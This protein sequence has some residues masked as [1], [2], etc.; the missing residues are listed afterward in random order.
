MTSSTHRYL[1]GFHRNFAYSRSQFYTHVPCI[2]AMCTPGAIPHQKLLF[3]LCACV[4]ACF[5]SFLNPIRQNYQQF[6]SIFGQ[7]SP[8]SEGMWMEDEE[9]SCV[10]WWYWVAQTGYR[11]YVWIELKGQNEKTWNK[12]LRLYCT[13]TES[14]R[15]S[16]HMVGMIAS[17]IHIRMNMV[18]LII[19]L[20]LISRWSQETE[21]IDNKKDWSL[22]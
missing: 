6:S 7:L 18:V 19:K 2:H 12:I 8:S 22:R 16:S 9:C 17:R 1:L 3:V 4:L 11:Y 10:N 5:G 15:E 20:L 21:S 14:V 13:E